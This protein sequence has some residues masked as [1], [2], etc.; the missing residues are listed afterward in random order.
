MNPVRIMALAQKEVIQIL[1]DPRALALAFV[2]PMILLFLFGYAI[3]LDIKN[4]PFGVLDYDKSN[5]VH[6]NL[7]KFTA[8]DANGDDIVNVGDLVYLVNYVF[9]STQC[10]VNPPIGCA[11]DPYE[12]GDA[13][14]DGNVDIGDA[15][16]ISNYIYKSTECATN[17]PIGCPP[18]C[19]P[20]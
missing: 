3:T 9:N 15:V 20:K 17:P 8:G 4:I 2:L 6:V 5:M 1:R 12:S 10:A 16:Y 13:N 18:V 7:H 19:C 11:P 14:C